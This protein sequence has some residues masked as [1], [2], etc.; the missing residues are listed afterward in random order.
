M[1]SIRE[2]FEEVETTKEYDGYYYQVGDIL[3]LYLKIGKSLVMEKAGHEMGTMLQFPHECPN[4]MRDVFHSIG[5]LAR[6]NRNLQS[7]IQVF[8]RIVFRSV[9]RQ[10]KH[11]CLRQSHLPNK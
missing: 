5:Q 2:Y 10:E 11:L 9:G 4:L 8:I 3:L 6:M 1:E 7:M